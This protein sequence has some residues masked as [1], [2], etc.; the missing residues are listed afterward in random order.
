MAEI[1]IRLP[2][3]FRGYVGG[4]DS[5]HVEAETVGGAL[6]ALAARSAALGERLLTPE[7][8]LRRFVN[9]YRGDDDIRRLQGLDTPVNAGCVLMILVA[10][11][12][13]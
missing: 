6:T 7:G 13:G 10:M 1:Q 8:R 4:A 11:A 3:Q 9:L 12:G 5:V 2:L